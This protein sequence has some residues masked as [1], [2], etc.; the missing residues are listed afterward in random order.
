MAHIQ[1]SSSLKHIVEGIT[2]LKQ[3]LEY[4]ERHAQIKN[5]EVKKEYFRT[6]SQVLEAEKA[7]HHFA[8]VFDSSSSSSN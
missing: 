8:E 4:F 3:Q 5:Q 7:I 2:H 6:L 1:K